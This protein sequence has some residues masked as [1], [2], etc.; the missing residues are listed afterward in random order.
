MTALVWFRQDLR[1]HDQLDL[2]RALERHEHVVPVFCFD[3][4]LLRGRHASGPRT[5]FMLESLTDLDAALRARGGA[6]VVRGG[7][8]EHELPAFAERVGAGEV[9]VTGGASRCA[10]ALRPRAGRARPRDA[11]RRGVDLLACRDS[12]SPTTWVT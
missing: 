1:V 2:R 12:P 6:L 3:D 4:R 5:Q 8:P 7:R 11:R 10:R 9:L